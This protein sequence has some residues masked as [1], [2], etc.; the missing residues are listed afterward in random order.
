M[1]SRQASPT[2][3]DVWYKVAP[4]RPRIS[5]H[6]TIVR[7]RFG[8]ATAFV[9]EETATGTFFRMSEAAYR[10]VGLLDGRRSIDEAWE[11]CASQ[12]GDDAP[13][14]SECI[15]L[16][17]TLDSSGL[18]IG[19]TP[20]WS[21]MLEH[22]QSASR[23]AIRKKRVGS[24]LFPCIPL[25]NP[26][27]SL[28]K[29]LHLY[30]WLFG[31][32]GFGLW[33]AVVLIAA[34]MVASNAGRFANELD[35]VA[36]MDPRNLAIIGVV[37][38]AL[39]IVHELGHAMACK[40][41]GGRC[42]ELG[43]M[44]VAMVLPL[45]Y[46]DATSSWSFPATRR[47][48]FVAA[49]GVYVETF[50]AALAAILWARS[51]PG[52]FSAVCRNVMVVSGVTTLLFNLNPLLRYDGYYILSDLLGIPNLAQRANE[53]WKY[54]ILR[55]A[56]GVLGSRPPNLRD[57]KELTIVA[58][59]ATLSVP[60]RIA[61]SLTIC[62]VVAQKYSSL[63]LLLGAACI[64]MM[65][66]WPLLKGAGFVLW[67]PILL[68]RRIRATSVVAGM[69][70]AL[71]LLL[72]VVPVRE[73]I[74]APG[75]LRAARSSVVRAGEGGYVTEVLAN[76]GDVVARGDP[77]I[78]L[79]N[80]D[81]EAGRLAAAA[82]MAQAEAALDEAS[83]KSPADRR[84]AQAQV[85]FAAEELAEAKS[86]VDALTIRAGETGTL[87][88]AGATAL[89]WT[90]LV[91]SF[92]SKGAMLGHVASLDDIHVRTLVDDADFEHAFT[93]SSSVV[94]HVRVRGLARTRVQADIER[95][96]PAGS[97]NVDDL[98]LAN[99]S[100]GDVAVRRTDDGRYESLTPQFVVDLRPQGE[101]L[102]GMLGQR[103]HARFLVDSRPLASQWSRR[104]RQFW[105]ER[106]GG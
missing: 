21:D 25:V 40:A 55:Y 8:D 4:L 24:G 37:F 38:L 16:L 32:A 50:F 100:G 63:G 9:I 33:T 53:L 5:P 39:R 35:L 59:Y 68:G 81:L 46:C 45:P 87:I 70:A 47:R 72:G 82:R 3:S 34:F 2:F 30:R 92:V 73:H 71:V 79:E 22:R 105:D 14:Q 106:F 44:L 43:L 57:R 93:G 36:M 23:A 89:D 10:F 76:V 74:D 42:T 98:A 69:I 58:I 12:I 41:M 67:S 52:L 18:L 61:V 1:I 29:T 78:R 11:A 64:T 75:V 99:V 60:Y 49:A 17:A 6:A 91:G 65:V 77:L 26:E 86:R 101:S 80:P 85:T 94:A 83:V 84:A 13:T 51:D 95:I 19:Q 27:R 28:T 15:E 54:V 102:R 66:V 90:N 31:W 20:V 48:V 88:A 96:A 97:L 104:F 62:L 7:Q 56:F 103:A